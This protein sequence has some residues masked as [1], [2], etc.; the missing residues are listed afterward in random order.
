MRQS[1]INNNLSRITKFTGDNFTPEKYFTDA[2]LGHSFAFEQ[3]TQR[4]NDVKSISTATTSQ[5]KE[6]SE[7]FID[8]LLENYS[9]FISIG[10]Y[11]DRIDKEISSLITSQKN[12]SNLI[13]NLRKDVEEFSFGYSKYLKDDVDAIPSM[14]DKDN[15][16]NVYLFENV[17]DE[18]ENDFDIDSFLSPKQGDKKWIEEQSEKLRVMID[19]KKFDDCVKVINDIRNCDLSIVDYDTRLA[20]DDVYSY[21]VEKITLAIGRCVSSKEVKFY[22]EKMKSIGCDGLAVDTFLNWLSKKMRSKIQKRI[23]NEDDNVVENKELNVIKEEDE[24]DNVDAPSAHQDKKIISIMTAYFTSFSKSIRLITEYFDIDNN[25]AFSTYIIPWLKTEMLSM[26][27]QLESLYSSLKSLNEMS[28]VLSFI[29]TLFSSLESKGQSAK[30]IYDMYFVVNLKIAFEAIVSNSMKIDPNRVPF[31]LKKYS[32]AYNDKKISLHCVSEIASSVYGVFSIM[33]EFISKFISMKSKFIGIVFI[34]E[35]F[36]DVLV[37]KEF[38]TYLK[39]KIEKNIAN[40]YDVKPFGD[41]NESMASSNQSLINYAISI[42]SIERVVNFFSDIIANNGDIC[43]SSKESLSLMK[44]NLID[45]KKKYFDNLL[46]VKIESHFY[47]YFENEKDSLSTDIAE[48]FKE[49][50]RV[51]IVFFQLIKNIAKMVKTRIDEDSDYYVRYFIFD[52]QFV[53]FIRI[54]DDVKILNEVYDTDFNLAKMGIFGMDIV[55]YGVIFVYTA[56]VKVLK[57]EDSD[58][59]FRKITEEF[60]ENYVKEWGKKRNMATLRFEDRN[61]FFEIIDKYV[62]ENKVELMKGY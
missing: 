8:I 38:F 31:D 13:H 29:T 3:K 1:T 47:R 22:L 34:E 55:V 50:D 62:N 53:N 19:E 15:D 41:N 49:V 35:F 32:I 56:I 14:N 16:N 40:N 54:I 6:T 18:D 45:T 48:Q 7:K 33:S 25:V 52:N 2:L 17:N 23:S 24:E 21:F 60:I 43:E 59:R 44:K 12:Y 51:F 37:S 61:K 36:F 30:F 57:F 11:V 27:K 26:N 20:I 10:K 58:K 46:K 42:L 9:T 28:N 39:E 5:Y 4:L